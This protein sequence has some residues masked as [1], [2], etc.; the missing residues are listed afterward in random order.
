MAGEYGLDGKT[1]DFRGKARMDAT[2]SH[3]TTGWKSVLLKPVDPFFRKDGAG[4]EIPIKI[5]GTEGAPRFGLDLG[6]KGE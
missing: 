3:M 2:V 4:T 5:T 1:F 6:H